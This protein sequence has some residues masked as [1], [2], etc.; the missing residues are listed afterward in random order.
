MNDILIT[1]MGVEE[2][3]LSELKGDIKRQILSNVLSRQ[4]PENKKYFESFR[5]LGTEEEKEEHSKFFSTIEKYIAS[6]IEKSEHFKKSF[7]GILKSTLIEIR[8]NKNSR[9]SRKY[10]NTDFFELIKVYVDEYYINESK[11]PFITIRVNNHHEHHPI[12]SSFIKDYIIQRVFHHLNTVPTEQGVKE[13]QSM[14]T[15]MSQLGKIQ[16]TVYLKSF[17]D[18]NNKKLYFDLCRDDWKILVVTKDKIEIKENKQ[19]KFKRF[20]HMKELKVDLTAKKEDIFL[21]TKG[22]HIYE[23]DKQLLLPT[24]IQSVFNYYPQTIN[25]IDGVKGSSKST[26][27]KKFREVIDPST[28]KVLIM[29]EDKKDLIFMLDHHFICGFDNITTISK[30]LSDFLCIVSTGGALEFRQLFT[31]DSSIFRYLLRKVIVNGISVNG[32]NTDLQDR[33]LKV[34]MLKISEKDRKTENSIWKEF[35]DVKEKI[36][37]AIFKIIQEFLKSKDQVVL[38]R[39]PRMADFAVIGEKIS[40]IIGFEEDNFIKLYFERINNAEDDSIENDMFAKCFLKYI[41]S[42]DSSGYEGT[43]T[44]LL[45]CINQVAV[46]QGQDIL[47]RYW[48]KNPSHLSRKIADYSSILERQGFKIDRDRT[49]KTRNIIITRNNLVSFADSKS[50]T[51]I[52]I[53]RDSPDKIF[54]IKELSK[55]LG[56]PKESVLIELENEKKE[57]NCFDPRENHWRYM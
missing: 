54:T 21:F 23:E 3:N 57:G 28:M 16:H 30:Q 19:I 36:S 45:N 2:I 27:T 42:L 13:I 1:E 53:L 52:D 49:G 4:Y 32:Y 39:T 18:K 17:F 35:D 48:I 55:K 6:T 9:N 47:N 25:F 26:I 50:I 10:I 46:S 14:M 31:D 11:T 37:G 7:E 8:E 24:L 41:Q 15:A 43:A 22:E 29:P 5:F 20:D 40:R 12:K 51:A 56:L 34:E 38:T 44:T 33:S